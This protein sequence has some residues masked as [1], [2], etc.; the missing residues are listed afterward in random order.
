MAVMRARL[1]LAHA[2]IPAEPSG[3]TLRNAKGCTARLTPMFRLWP[4][5]R[6][7]S[8]H[9]GGPFTSWLDSHS[10]TNLFRMQ[11]E[12]QQGLGESQLLLVLNANQQQPASS[13]EEDPCVSHV[14]WGSARTMEQVDL[15]GWAVSVVPHARGP[16]REMDIVN[17]SNRAEAAALIGRSDGEGTDGQIRL[18]YSF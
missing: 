13:P 1:L 3:A 16:G 8:S 15:G 12:G 10:F 9:K 5:A 18:L 4:D 14:K 11:S 2:P 7:R 17:D 6:S